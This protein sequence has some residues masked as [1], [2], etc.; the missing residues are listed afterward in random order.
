MTDRVL[1]F[2]RSSKRHSGERANPRAHTPEAAALR[3]KQ[4]KVRWLNKW[5]RFAR[6]HNM[7]IEVVFDPPQPT[8][9][10]TDSP[11]P[12]PGPPARRSRRRT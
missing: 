8:P 7:K 6:E 9:R 10:C 12:W 2:P 11:R 3:A 5:I 1:P 4:R